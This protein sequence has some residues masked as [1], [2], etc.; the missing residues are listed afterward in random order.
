MGEALVQCLYACHLWL[1]ELYLYITCVIEPDE[2]D[3][4]FSDCGCDIDSDCD[5][6]DQKN[7]MVDLELA[8]DNELIL[9]I[10]SIEMHA[11]KC[12]EPLTPPTPLDPGTIED[13][14]SASDTFEEL[15]SPSTPSDMSEWS[16]LIDE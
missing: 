3:V 13:L 14:S 15:E 2:D 4:I 10:T 16:D 11:S 12:G 8:S 1:T 9:D 5:F 6:E 7:Y